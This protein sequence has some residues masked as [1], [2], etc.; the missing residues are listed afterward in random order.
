MHPRYTTESTS[1]TGFILIIGCTLLLTSLPQ[2]LPNFACFPQRWERNIPSMIGLQNYW[3]SHTCFTNGNNNNGVV[4][5]RAFLFFWFHCLESVLLLSIDGGAID[6]IIFPFLRKRVAFLVKAWKGL[7]SMISL[8]ELR[9]WLQWLWPRKSKNKL[10]L[11]VKRTEI[12]HS[13][14]NASKFSGVA[15]R[16]L[17]V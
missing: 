14:C 12:L 10:K 9:F 17:H 16:I 6:F 8:L 3:S 5:V 1:A 11:R 13:L 2:K 15:A 4:K 7:F